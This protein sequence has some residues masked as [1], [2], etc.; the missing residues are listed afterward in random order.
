VVEG[1]G[2]A[3]TFHVAANG[4][5]ASVEGDSF[6]NT[7]VETA[8]ETLE[9]DGLG[10]PDTMTSVGNLGGITHLVYDGGAGADTLQGGNGADLLD[11]GAGGDT[12]DGNQGADTV[13]AGVGNDLVVWDPGDGSDTVEGQ[14]GTDTLAFNGSN[15]PELMDASANGG[16]V[17]FTRNL[18][19]I[20]MDLDGI[21][22]ID[23]R[24][25]GSPDELTVNDLSG[26]ALE[27]L[28][29]DL[30][31]NGGGGD[32]EPDTVI[33]NGTPSDDIVRVEAANGGVEARRSGNPIT[34]VL[35][36]EPNR[37]TLVV[38]G[39]AGEDVIKVD[40]NAQTLIQV[41]SNP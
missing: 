31:A 30:A 19:N 28:S 39:L 6:G 33:V 9:L 12:I 3:D 35:G 15:G 21:E 13:L 20:V 17:R 4:Q 10:G 18:G 22:R 11:G 27:R 34:R 40:P 29:V 36:A 38:N 2:D 7:R 24:T 14:S 26:T 5:V 23:V 32:G 1:T 37:D 25:L 16:R 41:I 8:D